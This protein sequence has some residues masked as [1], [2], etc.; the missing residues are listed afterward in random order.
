MSPIDWAIII[1]Y[2]LFA[3]GLGI[4][5]SKRAGKDMNEF[6]ISGR[7]LPWW[8]AGTSMV[9]TT[10]AADTPLAVTGLVVEDGIAGNWL[11]W[12]AVLSGML[13]TFLFA[14]LWRRSEIITD[15]EFTELRYSGPSA[16]FLRGFRAL[17]IGLP[18][19]CI[20]MGWV[21][22]AMQKIVV[23]TLNLPDTASTKV[24]VVLACLLIAGIYCALSGFWGVV[25][26]DIVQFGMAMVGSIALAIIAVNKIG[27][28]GAIKEKLVNIYGAENQILN[29]TPDFSAGK[30][31]IITFGVYLGM[32]WWASNGVDGSG[33]IAQRMFAAKNERHTL[34]ATLWF[35][36][37]HYTLRPWPWILVALVAMV[38]YPNLGDP[39]HANPML[40]DPE[41]G[42]PLLMLEYL[43]VGLLGLMLTAFLAA[44]MSTIDTH[45]NWGASYLVNDFYKRFFKPEAEPQH[46][47]AISRFAVILIMIVA[48]VTSLFMDSIA[49]AWKFLI[50]LNA[51]IGLVQILRWYWWRINAWSEI[52]AMLAALVA[53]IVV[54]TLPQTK[55][56][57]AIQM[58]IIVPISTVVWVVVTFITKP[59]S[60]ETLTKFYSKVKPSK[61]GW[62]LVAAEIKEESDDTNRQQTYVE[63]RTPALV[64]WIVGV[65]FIYTFLFSI[66]KLLLGFTTIGLSFLSIAIISGYIMYK[67]L[68]REKRTDD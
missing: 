8:L 2:I 40:Q 31:A 41:A 58:L 63:T 36:I 23:L 48:G 51:G 13:A 57:F 61:I 9:A 43:P 38:V 3:L 42:Y 6:F 19:N 25:M 12:N 33:Y 52:S 50:A 56:Q 18:I 39:N 11:W 16:S 49:G 15:V 35:N 27:G 45:L 22:L 29:F 10:F 20:T 55:D 34:L 17:Y 37:A 7:N 68:P 65:I 5:F 59:V 30:M 28:V 14:R 62:M 64:N 60:T 1:G 53:S 47:V 26:T 4:Y 32:Q 67:N 66:G 54:F 46:Y 44:F 21:I 24:V